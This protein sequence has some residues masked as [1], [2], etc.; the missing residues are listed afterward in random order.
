MKWLR[1]ALTVAML[2]LYGAVF[3]VDV[4]QGLPDH[5]QPK[6]V[7]PSIPWLGKKRAP[8][9]MSPESSEIREW[10]KIFETGRDPF[11]RVK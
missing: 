4:K 6:I 10:E 11:R 8:G 1:I 2:S 9:T 5:L 7:D 3:A